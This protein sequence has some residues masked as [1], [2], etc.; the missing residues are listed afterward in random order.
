[1]FVNSNGKSL[2]LAINR[3]HASTNIKIST[4]GSLL[5]SQGKRVHWETNPLPERIF[6]IFSQMLPQLAGQALL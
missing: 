3:R 6:H 1:M 4:Y 5:S 2:S